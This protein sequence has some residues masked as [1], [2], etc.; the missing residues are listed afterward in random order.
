MIAL[1]EELDWRCY[2]LYDLISDAPEFADPPPL[3]L[4][5]RA[6]EIV[7]AR[8]IAAGE[9][10]TAWFARHRSTPITEAP[11][12][13]PA[14]YRAVVERRITLIENSPTIGLI[15]R[16]EYKR[17]WLTEP[18]ETLEQDALRGGLR[19]SPKTGQVAKRESPLGAAGRP[20]VRHGENAQ[21]AW[22]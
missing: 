18:W 13:W 21:E 8:K 2:R 16:P 3:W 22:A 15:E 19:W 5:E 1:Q 6:F 4:G 10:E 11:Q 9:L 7:M 12:H 17:R 14:D 20:G